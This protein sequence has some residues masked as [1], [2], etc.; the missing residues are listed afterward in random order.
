MLFYPIPHSRLFNVDVAS[1]RFY[2]FRQVLHAIESRPAGTTLTNECAGRLLHSNSTT[3]QQ[4]LLIASL[5]PS[6]PH[7]PSHV[8]IPLVTTRNY[9]RIEKLHNRIT[10]STCILFLSLF[11]F[12]FHP[13]MTSGWNTRRTSWRRRNEQKV[14]KLH[15][16]AFKPVPPVLPSCQSSRIAERNAWKRGCHRLVSLSLFP[17]LIHKGTYIYSSNSSWSSVD[18]HQTTEAKKEDEKKKNLSF[19]K[20]DGI[21][22]LIEC[23]IPAL[24]WYRR[25][26]V[27]LHRG[28]TKNFF[29]SRRAKTK[30]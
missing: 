9:K 28:P 14:K 30:L 19:S 20:E 15:C 22:W 3:L 27:Y 12:F 13:L 6:T 18:I 25:V 7:R 23:Q 10:P 8:L 4:Q 21:I 29:T 24:Q 16:F 1:C 26:P 2:A 17:S 11:F 5:I